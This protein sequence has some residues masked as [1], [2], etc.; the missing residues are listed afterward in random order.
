MSKVYKVYMH[1]TPS[2]KR[3]IGYTGNILERRWGK[4]INYKQHKHFYAAIKKYGWDNIKHDVL[5][6]TFD[7]EDA[8]SKEIYFISFYKSNDR[9]FGYNSSA[10]GDSGFNGGKHSEHYKERLKKERSIAKWSET[11]NSIP[12]AQY[13]LEGNFISLFN[14]ISEASKKTNITRGTI[15][16]GCQNKVKSPRI[17]LWEYCLDKKPPKIID[18]KTKLSFRK[19]NVLFSHNGETKTLKQLAKENGIEYSTLSQRVRRYNV[20]LETA[21]KTPVCVSK[22]PLKYRGGENAKK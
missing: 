5:Y 13:D 1:T 4:G 19:D 7:K 6:E 20:P 22:I 10:G 21:L 2:G 16:R 9:R 17:F 12:V 14:S 11:N 18:P 15:E 3:Y 8:L